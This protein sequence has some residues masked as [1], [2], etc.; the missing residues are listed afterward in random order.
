[1]NV[2]DTCPRF[3]LYQPTWYANMSGWD[4]RHA[5]VQL[6]IRTY[7]AF[8]KAFNNLINIWNY[9][10][11]SDMRDCLPN[12][13]LCHVWGVTQR[14]SR[15]GDSLCWNGWWQGFHP[16]H[17][18]LFVVILGCLMGAVWESSRQTGSHLCTTYT[19]TYMNYTRAHMLTGTCICQ[20]FN[21]ILAVV[22][23]KLAGLLRGGHA[24]G[25]K[26]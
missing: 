22:S 23:I 14:Y 20:K 25:I 9:L 5:T 7:L 15:G 17:W 24:Y 4:R 12:P 10:L 11:W 26:K 3:L 16:T 8:L 2:V 1:M 6:W 13:S 21:D 19:Y 18:G